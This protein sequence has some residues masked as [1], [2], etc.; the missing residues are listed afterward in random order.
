M[1]ESDGLE[2]D[3]LEAS[4]GIDMITIL[5]AVFILAIIF[6]PSI[7]RYYKQKNLQKVAI[8]SPSQAPVPG[9]IQPAPNVDWSKFGPIR[10]KSNNGTV[11]IK[12][13][14]NQL[15]N[16]IKENQKNMSS[17]L[18]EVV[19][20]RNDIYGK[21]MNLREMDVDLQNKEGLLVNYLS[22]IQ[23]FLPAEEKIPVC[24]NCKIEMVLVEGKQE[25]VCPQCGSKCRGVNDEQKSF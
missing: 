24:K 10:T 3:A 12:E 15:T 22:A 19:T 5:F 6:G 1:A 2:S 7:Y 9:Q 8:P 25:Y 17:T 14:I 23:Q 18:K 16:S 11:P 4:G 21:A 20:L 13:T